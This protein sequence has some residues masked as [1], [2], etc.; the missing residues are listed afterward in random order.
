MNHSQ[1]GST[2]GGLCV[3]CCLPYP[4]Q[5]INHCLHIARGIMPLSILEWNISVSYWLHALVT[6]L[7]ILYD[8]CLVKFINF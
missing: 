2:P 6:F 3:R 7:N 1:T 5:Y 4:L 8:Y